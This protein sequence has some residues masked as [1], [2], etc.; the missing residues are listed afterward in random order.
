MQ[1]STRTLRASQNHSIISG[2]L[3]MRAFSHSSASQRLTNHSRAR[4]T[5]L[6]ALSPPHASLIGKLDAMVKDREDVSTLVDRA[7]ETVDNLARTGQSLHG[8]PTEWELPSLP[9]PSWEM[10]SL[11]ELPKAVDRIEHTS[12]LGMLDESTKDNLDLSALLGR[13]H[14]AQDAL[15]LQAASALTGQGSWEMPNWDLTEMP[16]LDLPDLEMPQFSMDSMLQ[17]CENKDSGVRFI[18]AL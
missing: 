10:I 1:H 5:A 13:L 6:K 14:E 12:M 3:N 7:R 2:L 4:G 18:Y 9:T 8:L 16:A 17:V 15:T 11:P